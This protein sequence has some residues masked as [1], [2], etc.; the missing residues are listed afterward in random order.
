MVVINIDKVAERHEEERGQSYMVIY[1]YAKAT[2]R[3]KICIY[4]GLYSFSPQ[5]MYYLSELKETT[6]CW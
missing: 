5:I 1:C 2:V 6:T 3:K 4:Q